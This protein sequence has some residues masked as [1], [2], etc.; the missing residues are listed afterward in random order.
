MSASTLASLS[1]AQGRR[2]NRSQQAD[3]ALYPPTYA[4]WPSRTSTPSLERSG[5]TQATA[6]KKRK[7]PIYFGPQLELCLRVGTHTTAKL[8]CRR[9]KVR[10]G[11]PRMLQAVPAAAGGALLGMSCRDKTI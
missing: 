11:W 8:P 2:R 7:Y 10:N 9:T 6:R 5:V 4:P 3:S 1:P